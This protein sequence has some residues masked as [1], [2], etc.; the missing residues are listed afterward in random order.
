MQGRVATG[1]GEFVVSNPQHGDRRRRRARQVARMR[2]KKTSV[3]I[4]LGDPS[5]PRHDF[6]PFLVGRLRPPTSAQADQIVFPLGELAEAFADPLQTNAFSG[7]NFDGELLPMLIGRAKYVE[8]P[9][10]DSANRKYKIHDGAIVDFPL[11]HGPRRIPRSRWI[12]ARRSRAR[13]RR[14]SP[15]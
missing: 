11:P 15:R 10:Y 2:W 4:L 14:G 8:P 6:R 9:L 1:F 12:T 13:C 3:T 7:G 5:W